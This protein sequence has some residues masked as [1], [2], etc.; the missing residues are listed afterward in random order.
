M[1]KIRFENAPSTNTPINADNLNKLNNVVVSSSEPTTGEEVWIQ[2]GK[3]LIDTS[4]FI[5]NTELNGT[6]GTTSRD[7]YYTTP[8]ILVN[9]N[10]TY[11]LSGI[12]SPNGFVNNYKDYYDEN[13]NF[14]R[15]D[16]NAVF[17]T[18]SNAKYVRFNG[19]TSYLSEIQLEQDSRVTSFE[20]YIEKKIYTKNDNGVYEEF[21]Q[22]GIE[23]GSNENGSWIKF[24]DGTMICR[25]TK[26][27]LI[28]IDT[29]WGET[30]YIGNYTDEIIFPHKFIATPDLV[31]NCNPSTTTGFF[32]GS[33]EGI[34]MT[35][36]GFSGVTLI[37]P[38][39]RTNVNAK[40]NFIAIGRWK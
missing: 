33:F 35:T 24:D 7:G 9:S 15:S 12:K 3:N 31:Y 38:N 39:S 18:P 6:G 29:L 17:T 10:T 5:Y 21:K 36:T 20:T 16:E 13:Y 27:L 22:D 19:S 1:T 4:T 26:A 37:R 34:T 28:D 11:A 30:L 40:I 25:G 23:S 8:F 32:C 14:I 2:K